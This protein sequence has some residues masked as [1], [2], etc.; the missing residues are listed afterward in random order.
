MC[1][2][3]PEGNVAMPVSSCSKMLELAM[4]HR[5]VLS[6]HILITYCYLPSKEVLCLDAVSL[7]EVLS[8]RNVMVRLCLSPCAGVG[9]LRICSEC[10]TSVLIELVL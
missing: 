7:I 4:P 2:R 8:A 5:F 1:V 6:L 9:R 3:L 10:G